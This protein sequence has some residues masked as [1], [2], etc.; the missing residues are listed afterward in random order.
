MCKD[1]FGKF[2]SFGG[3]VV[4][5]GNHE[6][7]DFEPDGCFV[8]EPLKSLQN[9]FEVGEGDF[10]VEI[11]AEG[12]EVNIGSIDVIVNVVKGF[13]GNIAVSDHDGSQ[14]VRF[15]GFANVDDVLAPDGGFVVGEGD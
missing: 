1:P 14:S 8:L 2:A 13:A 7:G 9:R 4:E 10:P 3:I 12:F 5:G 15:G 11:F 6:I